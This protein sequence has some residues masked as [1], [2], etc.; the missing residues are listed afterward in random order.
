MRSISLIITSLL[1]CLTAKAQTADTPPDA[2][3]R[4]SGDVLY[5]EETVYNEWNIRLT[6]GSGTADA[7]QDLNIPIRRLESVSCHR[8]D[9]SGHER[10]V[11]RYVQRNSNIGDLSRNLEGSIVYTA[12][13]ISRD[14]PDTRLT[15][16][17]RL[18]RTFVKEVWAYNRTDSIMTRRDS[19]YYDTQGNLKGSVTLFDSIQMKGEIEGTDRNGSYRISYQD[20]TQQQFRFDP[21]GFLIRYTDRDGM[22]VKYSYNDRGHLTRQTS[23]WTDGSVLNIVYDEY[24]YDTQ[25]NWIQR[26]RKVKDPGEQPRSVK[27]VTRTYTYR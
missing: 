27:T 18:D 8:F 11:V 10:Q 20:G 4:M 1:L 22:T 9:D 23:E 19:C 21:D 25:G 24:Q 13:E 26:S 17:Y 5:Y 6:P 3:E 15:T 14:V 2:T 12:N 7:G 16:V